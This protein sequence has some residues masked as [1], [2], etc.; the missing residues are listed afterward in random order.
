MVGVADHCDEEQ[1]LVVLDWEKIWVVM[2]REKEKREYQEIKMSCH[3]KT[4]IGIWEM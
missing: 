4:G 3:E 2:A 1:E